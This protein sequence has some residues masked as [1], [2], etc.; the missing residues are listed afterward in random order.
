M[1]RFIALFATVCG[2]LLMG[3]SAQAGILWEY[4]FTPSSSKVVSDSGNNEIT[5]SNQA[6]FFAEGSSNVVATSLAVK[7]PVVGISD[8]FTNPQN[9]AIHMFLK[10][11]A[12]GDFTTLIF[13]GNLS[14]SISFSTNGSSLLENIFNEENQHQEATLGGNKYAVELTYFTPPSPPGQGGH[15]GAIGGTVTVTPGGGEE[16]HDTPEPSTMLLA[17][18]GLAGF[19]LNAWRKR[20]QR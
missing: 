2:V 1:K 13:S 4:N 9:Y 11:T 14:G 5:F 7:T 17:G 18:F 12:S 3:A 20:R 8:T 6:T 10:D 16:P 19:G 15:P